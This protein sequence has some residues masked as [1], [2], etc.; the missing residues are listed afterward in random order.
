MLICVLYFL[1]VFYAVIAESISSDNVNEVNSD[2]VTQIN[3]LIE[4]LRNSRY[5]RPQPRFRT[6]VPWRPDLEIEF[7]PP[8]Y[9]RKRNRFWPNPRRGG[10]YYPLSRRTMLTNPALMFD[11]HDY[12]RFS[13]I[14]RR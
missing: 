11:P 3:N 8:R 12:D 1:V 14:S 9:R 7:S 5:S 13:D 6:P 4:K 10:R 2:H